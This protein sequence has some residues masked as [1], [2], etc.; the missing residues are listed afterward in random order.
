MLESRILVGLV[1]SIFGAVL[2]LLV[3]RLRNKRGLFTYF[4]WHD[5]VGL[6]TED[7]VFGTVRVTSNDNP[8]GNLYLSR[9]ELRNESLNDY[10]GIVFRVLANNTALLSESTQIVGT[11][12]FLMWTEEFS[13]KLSVAHGDVATPYQLELVRRQR[14][15]QIPTMNRG[16]RIQL[17]FLNDA[18]PGKMPWLGLELLHK[19]VR[20]ESRV[21]KQQFMGVPSPSAALA[22]SALGLV[23]LLAVVLT[24][25]TTWVAATLCLAFGLTVQIPGALAIKS[26]RWFRNSIGN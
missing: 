15:F 20:L 13:R 3:Q 10:E 21:A 6:S 14:E 23:F 22:G 5:P 4:V 26:W 9:V 12:H 17:R 1:A 2:A 7:S 11:T 16:Q 8:V 25:E 19:G 18:V 24:I